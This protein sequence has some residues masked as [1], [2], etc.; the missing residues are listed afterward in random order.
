MKPKIALQLWSIKEDCEQDFP[1]ALKEV[2][3][4]GY[5]GVEFAGYYG[6][7]AAEVRQLLDELDLEVAGSHVPYENLVED[8]EGTIAFEKTI[9]NTRI[10]IPFMSFPDFSGWQQFA[11]ELKI[12]APKLAKEGL[13]LYYHNHAHEFTEVPEM[14]L[15]DYLAKEVPELKL[16]VDVY[17]VHDAGLNVEDWL[18]AQKEKI[19][20][21]HIKEMQENP[22]ESTEIGKGILPIA[23][24]VKKAKA[25]D[26]P[27]LIIEQ[28]AFQTLTPMA[29]VRENYQVLT[30]IVEECH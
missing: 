30:K 7:K 23:R 10:V 11:A 28:E 19:G 27:W 6:L 9:G 8:Y 22:K 14:D 2:K 13:T 12:L 18:E 26:L 4:A 17:W 5:A 25:L 20:L 21:L 16:E 3:K 24:Y 15:L 1:N 29:A